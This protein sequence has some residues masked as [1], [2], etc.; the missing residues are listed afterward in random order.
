MDIQ[1]SFLIKLKIDV[2]FYS[3]S[4]FP[5]LFTESNKVILRTI[6]KLK[7]IKFEQFKNGC[8]L[9]IQKYKFYIYEN[10]TIR[11]E[12]FVREWKMETMEMET[13]KK[14]YASIILKFDLRY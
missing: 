2:S 7:S 12:K 11:F 4:Q 1:T 14:K 13:T 5:K 8:I 3:P 9:F 6:S 10:T